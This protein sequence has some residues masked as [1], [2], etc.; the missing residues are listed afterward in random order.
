MGIKKEEIIIIIILVII[1]I[2]VII[3]VI[4]VIG[5]MPFLYQPAVFVLIT[6]IL[7]RQLV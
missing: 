7:D 5:S 1:I 4:T 6:K 2:M 3:I